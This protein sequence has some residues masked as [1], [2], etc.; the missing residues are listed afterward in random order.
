MEAAFMS[1]CVVRVSRGVSGVSNPINQLQIM[2]L[3]GQLGI[4]PDQKWWGTLRTNAVAEHCVRPHCTDPPLN[5]G[6]SACCSHMCP[7]GQR[8]LGCSGWSRGHPR[9][10][11][12]FSSVC[13]LLHRK[14]WHFIKQQTLSHSFDFLTTFTLRF[15]DQKY[16]LYGGWIIW[17]IIWESSFSWLSS[18]LN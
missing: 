5:F 11:K 4:V 14:K 1:S 9:L 6:S 17:E 18:I 3:P 16:N 12:G 7:L 13:E 15:T 8:F 2:S 10:L